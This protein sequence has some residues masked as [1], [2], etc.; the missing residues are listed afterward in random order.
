M[1]T[2]KGQLFVIAGSL[3]LFGGLI[4]SNLVLVILGFLLLSLVIISAMIKVFNEIVS[5]KKGAVGKDEDTFRGVKFTRRMSTYQMMEDSKSSVRLYVENPTRTTKRFELLD[6]LPDKVALFTGRNSAALTIPKRDTTILDYQIDCPIK[7]FFEIGPIRIR[8]TDICQF[9]YD[10]KQLRANTDFKVYPNLSDVKEVKLRSKIPK[11]Y[12]G[13]TIINKPGQG[14]EFYTVRDYVPGDA[15]RDI[16]W[17]AF[18]RTRKLM[19]NEHEM[20]AVIELTIILDYRAI[21]EKGKVIKNTHLASARAAASLASYFIRR[22]D[23]VGL[24]VYNKK[25]K[26]VHREAGAKHLNRLN[27]HI[28]GQAVK[29]DL[30][31]G[32]V[33]N[34]VIHDIQKGMPVVVISTLEKD[35]TAYQGIKRL[36]AN[37]CDVILVCPTRIPAELKEARGNKALK[38]TLRL[39]RLERK[40]QLE[41]IRSL[42]VKV[43]DWNIE[44]PFSNVMAKGIG[45]GRWRL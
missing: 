31:L 26:Y 8:E 11:L 23:K 39:V 41:Q 35:P 38:D 27:N 24:A 6:T 29:G 17:P 16:N 3:S 30:P 7:G 44:L 4:F 28:T 12:A 33:V 36:R 42:G 1:W 18:A 34:T 2:K 13:T 32:A 21:T 45:V 22:R 37:G 15:F 40:Q 14:T 5:V 9:F 10:E 19:V 25:V 43:V 20:E